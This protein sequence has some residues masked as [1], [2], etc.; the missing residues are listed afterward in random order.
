[1]SQQRLGRPAG[2]LGRAR[3][4][5]FGALALVVALAWLGLAA[6]GCMPERRA[7]EKDA[8]AAVD[9]AA[10]AAADVAADAGDAGKDQAGDA[11]GAGDGSTDPAPLPVGC[12]SDFECADLVDLPCRVGVCNLETGFCKVVDEISGTPC[13]PNDCMPDATCLSGECSGTV[14]DCDD[15][16]PCTDDDC[17]PIGGCV[18]PDNAAPC[19]DGDACTGGDAC[20]AGT[21]KGQPL[22]CQGGKPP[23]LVASCSKDKGCVV[24]PAELAKGATV[25]CSDEFA[26]TT[27]D[28]CQGGECVGVP[29]VCKDDGNPCTLEGCVPSEGKCV[30]TPPPPSPTWACSDNNPCTIEDICQGT[31]CKGKVKDCSDGNACSV[32]GCDPKIGC[33]YVQAQKGV[34]CDDGKLCT[35]LDSCDGSGGSGGCKGAAKVCDDGNLCTVDACSEGKGCSHVAPQG[36]LA[37]SDGDPCTDGDA[38]V[39]LVCKG[40]SA[41]CDD[42]D[43]CTSDDCGP[44]GCTY[45]VLKNGTACAGGQCWGGGCV[46]AKCGNGAC[47]YNESTALCAGDCPEGGGVCDPKDATCVN[48]CV[49][50]KCGA[51]TT[52]CDADLGCKALLACAGA[53]A[54]AACA[55]ACIA[56]APPTSVS[57][58]RA[59]RLCQSSKCLKNG[60]SG[61][62]CKANEPQFVS[63]VQ[64]CQAA[65]CVVEEATC[66]ASAGCKAIADCADLCT[67]GTASCVKACFANGSAEDV[68]VYDT[69]TVCMNLKCL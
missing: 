52:A 41:K 28:H 7:D 36:S 8:S 38:C 65:V 14:T 23:C 35:D 54:D 22:V 19:D 24:E 63:C 15:D 10:A 66:F 32:D 12:Q 43:P 37:C 39:D 49:A 5:A 33:T 31:D 16:D 1:M 67:D 61:K 29:L 34:V 51:P 4:L 55:Y 57:L 44:A 45:T 56:K 46:V 21:C 17:Q 26:C 69:L 25:T 53:C 59:L 48:D 2:G 68:S 11:A 20:D 40:Q 64:S 47:E 13:N 6:P 27:T 9:S 58:W 42:G 50:S 62:N 60:W 18:H 3:D 30:S